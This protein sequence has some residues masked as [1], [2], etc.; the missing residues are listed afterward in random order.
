MATVNPELANVDPQVD[1]LRRLPAFKEAV[2]ELFGTDHGNV[3]SAVAEFLQGEPGSFDHHRLRVIAAAASTFEDPNDVAHLIKTMPLT[4]MNVAAHVIDLV[5]TREDFAKV[6]LPGYK[7][8]TRR[9]L[10]KDLVDE[11]TLEILDNSPFEHIPPRARDIMRPHLRKRLKDSRDGTSVLHPAVDE[12]LVSQHL[13]DLE[14]LLESRETEESLQ[15]PVQRPL[16]RTPN[17]VLDPQYNRIRDEDIERAWKIYQ[18]GQP[19]DLTLSHAVGN[20]RLLQSNS[21]S[22]LVEIDRF[23]RGVRTV[24]S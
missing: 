7:S 4:G 10:V 3:V 24:G 6:L 23:V 1:G 2:K 22:V 21:Q 17:L 5:Q 15:I 19:W 13:D 8:I 14:A 18:C 11:A 12:E 20:S 9:R 16:S